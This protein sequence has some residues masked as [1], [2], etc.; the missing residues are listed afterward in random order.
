MNIAYL[1]A[2]MFIAFIWLAGVVL[3]KGAGL[4]AAAILLPPYA[5]YL[6]VERVLVAIGWAQ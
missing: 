1:F 6:V 3:A 5:F 4:T 2:Q